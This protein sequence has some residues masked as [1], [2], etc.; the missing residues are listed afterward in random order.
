MAISSKLA[1]QQTNRRQSLHKV[2]NLLLEL[3]SRPAQVHIKE[4]NIQ[5]RQGM[6]LI[7]RLDMGLLME[8][9]TLP[10]MVVALGDIMEANHNLQT[11]HMQP[12]AI[13]GY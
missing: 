10:P 5:V 7:K 3:S 9:S 2:N 1:I 8:V 11:V 13:R 4:A 6:V 12:K